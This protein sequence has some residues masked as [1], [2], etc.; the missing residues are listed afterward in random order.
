MIRSWIHT[1]SSSFMQLC[2]CVVLT[3]H[4]TQLCPLSKID[5]KSPTKTDIISF[6]LRLVFFSCCWK[7]KTKQFDNLRTLF[8]FYSTA[9][10][11]D[12][13]LDMILLP[14]VLTSSIYT[15]FYPKT[16]NLL[17]SIFGRMD[18]W[19]NGCSLTLLFTFSIVIWMN[20]WMDWMNSSEWTIVIV[21]A[22]TDEQDNWIQ[23]NWIFWGHPFLG[24]SVEH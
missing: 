13:N 9:I 18:G 10:D 7:I 6:I 15:H 17:P 14:S 11:V 2:S 8:F 12:K 23:L 3:Q 4:E 24:L 16:P 1:C 19:E 5:V 20:E 22:V 21:A